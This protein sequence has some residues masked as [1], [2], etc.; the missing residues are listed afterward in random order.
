[1]ELRGKKMTETARDGEEIA[2]DWERPEKK[3]CR[4][5]YMTNR[6]RGTGESN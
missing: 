6:R 5:C 4:C 3:V 2:M 1:M